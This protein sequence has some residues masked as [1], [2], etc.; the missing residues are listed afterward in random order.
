MTRYAAFAL[1]ALACCGPA[2]NTPHVSRDPIS[3]R[4]WITDVEQAPTTSFH[5]VETEA[6]RKIHLFQSTNVWID[7][8]PYV[9]GGVAENGSFI[10]LD[11]PP[12]NV[13]I[14]FSAPGVPTAHLVL[15]RVPGNADV[16]IPGL[17]LK[18]DSVAL[19]DPN[20]VKVRLA[21][22]VKRP[23]PTG[24][25]A[26]VAGL[27]V[28]VIDTPLAAMIDRLDY[29]NPPSGPTPIATYK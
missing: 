21:A 19:V 17:L 24:K 22:Q 13:T 16:F 1:L 11:V 5:T 29:P 14:S 4:G 27:P 15:E 9:S 26:V 8:A 6:A 7:N 2:P 25:T 18:H 23:T 20:G 12:G 28:P 10:L 3:V